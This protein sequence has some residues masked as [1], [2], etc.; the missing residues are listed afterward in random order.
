MAPCSG[1]D[2]AGSFLLD[3]KFVRISFLSGDSMALAVRHGCNFSIEF[4]GDL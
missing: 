4:G 1:S 2:P 3:G